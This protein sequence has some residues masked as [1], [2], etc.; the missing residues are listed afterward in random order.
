MATLSIAEHIL[1]TVLS[2]AK[3][4]MPAQSCGRQALRTKLLRD[5]SAHSYPFIPH[6]S[7]LPLLPLHE[8]HSIVDSKHINR[9]GKKLDQRG[10]QVRHK[11][12]HGLARHCEQGTRAER[13]KERPVQALYFLA[14]TGEWQRKLSQYH[15][16]TTKWDEKEMSIFCTIPNL[17]TLIHSIHSIPSAKGLN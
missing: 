5:F 4:W 13:S 14:K 2:Q 3:C 17:S 7:R 6:P 12:Y 8:E 11:K 1:S 9:S 15:R 10:R 16:K